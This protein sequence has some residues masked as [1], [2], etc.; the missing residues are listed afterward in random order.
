[1]SHDWRT[2]L[3]AVVGLAELLHGTRLDARHSASCADPPV[4]AHAAGCDR[5][6]A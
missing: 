4:G 1:M 5:R 2:P 3:N 6:R